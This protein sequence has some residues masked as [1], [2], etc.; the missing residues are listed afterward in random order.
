[1]SEQQLTVVGVGCVHA[2]SAEVWCLEVWCLTPSRIS[3]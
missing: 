1:M 2:I 3:V